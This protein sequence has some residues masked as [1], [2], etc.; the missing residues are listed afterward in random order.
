[1]LWYIKGISQEISILAV[2]D[3]A[4]IQVY[5]ASD[6]IVLTKTLE[7]KEEKV[8]EE[9]GDGVIILLINGRRIVKVF[10]SKFYVLGKAWSMKLCL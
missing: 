8:N 7:K 2:R 5:V 10:K 3:T 9:G 4:F 6:H 1:M